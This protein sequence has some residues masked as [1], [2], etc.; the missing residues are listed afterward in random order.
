LHE[1]VAGASYLLLHGKDEY[2]KGGQLFRIVSEGP[3]VFS[4]ETLQK[5]G[6]PGS[7]SHP[8]YLVFDIKP[9]DNNDILTK[10]N[11]D[12]RLIDGIGDG[13]QSAIPLKGILLS[14]FMKGAKNKS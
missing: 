14:D 10:Y 11:W 5:A 4:S 13:R 12:L 3:R 8:Y 7:C 6:Y 1:S 2:Q 9:L